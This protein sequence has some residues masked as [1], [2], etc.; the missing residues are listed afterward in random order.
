LLEILGDVLRAKNKAVIDYLRELIDGPE[1]CS[2]LAE[3]AESNQ[4]V[5]TL[6]PPEEAAKE[7]DF[8]GI[9]AEINTIVHSWADKIGSV[10]EY[11][12]TVAHLAKT[13][14]F[15]AQMTI[16]QECSSSELSGQVTNVLQEAKAGGKL[17]AKLAAK[18][19]ESDTSVEVIVGSDS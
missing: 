9:N 7:I 3:A 6:V 5:V 16:M 1:P 15:T 2:W 12:N 17:A 14:A 13:A 18:E 8:R 10:E 4:N 19:F 11:R